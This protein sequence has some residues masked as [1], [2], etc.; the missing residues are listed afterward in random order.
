MLF[1]NP[2][3]T[4]LNAKHQMNISVISVVVQCLCSTLLVAGSHR[5]SA[6]KELSASIQM[7]GT[8][9]RSRNCSPLAASVPSHPYKYRW[10]S[11][12]SGTLIAVLSVFSL[13]SPGNAAAWQASTLDKAEWLTC[14]KSRAKQWN[15]MKLGHVL[16]CMNRQH[17]SFWHS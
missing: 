6:T 4:F 16:G 5:P 7:A 12:M 10:H 14:C 9:G 11:A 17:S 13:G 8:P 3:V 2:Y 1:Y 15:H